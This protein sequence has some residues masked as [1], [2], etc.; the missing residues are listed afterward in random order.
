MVVITINSIFPLKLYLEVCPYI[1]MC[2]WD[3]CVWVCVGG[4]HVTCAGV[5]WQLVGESVLSITCVPGTELGSTGFVASASTSS[6]IFLP[7]SYF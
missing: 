1:F 3:F 2:V 4:A 6:A 5:R 7:Q